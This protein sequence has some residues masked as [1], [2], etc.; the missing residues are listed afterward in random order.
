MPP[1]WK[2]LTH[3]DIYSFIYAVDLPSDVRRS[4][5]PVRRWQIANFIMLVV[6]FNLWS[7]VNFTHALRE[8]YDKLTSSGA[9]VENIW[10][11]D[12][13]LAIAKRNMF[14]DL[15]RLATRAQAA[16]D[17]LFGRFSFSFR[18]ICAMRATCTAKHHLI[19]SET[20]IR[21]SDDGSE[22]KKKKANVLVSFD[23]GCKIVLPWLKTLLFWP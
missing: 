8:Y 22:R 7:D 3:F 15:Y 12:N 20:S 1:R 5:I 6:R 4:W 16:N 11:D 23:A 14:L 13:S 18:Y 2:H 9:Q 17:W 19:E 21:H 10:F